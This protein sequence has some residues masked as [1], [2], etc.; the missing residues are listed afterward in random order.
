M[1]V[2][3][4]NMIRDRNWKEYNNMLVKRGELSFYIEPAA[5]MQREEIKKLNDGKVGKPFTYGGFDITK[6]RDIYNLWY[7]YYLNKCI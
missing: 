2:L 6:Y 7:N 4:T 1:F 3:A 5:L